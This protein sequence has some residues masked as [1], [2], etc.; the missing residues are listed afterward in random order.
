[1]GNL[2][3]WIGIV[4]YNFLW[5][6][7]I[8]SIRCGKELRYYFTRLRNGLQRLKLF[9]CFFTHKTVSPNEPNNDEY[10][11][12]TYMFW[13][14]LICLL[15][16]PVSLDLI[17]LFIVFTPE[18]G[19]SADHAIPLFLYIFSIIIISLLVFI[20]GLLLY[21]FNKPKNEKETDETE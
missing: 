16:L 8:I 19:Y 20:I 4:I 11:Q 7:L 10:S 1:M 5:S 6:G 18:G 2:T 9:F 13:G 12:N 17:T 21:F 14:K 15:T 3:V